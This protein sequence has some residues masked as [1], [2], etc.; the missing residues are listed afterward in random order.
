[1]HLD[2][3]REILLACGAPGRPGIDQDELRLGIREHL[4][5]KLLKTQGKQGDSCFLFSNVRLRGLIVGRNCSTDWSPRRIHDNRDEHCAEDGSKY[6]AMHVEGPEG[7]SCGWKG[8]K[9]P[10]FYAR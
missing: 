8:R 10:Q 4:L 1:M 9:S 2:E 3:M 7:S 6:Q 5:L